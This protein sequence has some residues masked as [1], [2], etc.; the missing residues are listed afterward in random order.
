MNWEHAEAIGVG[1]EERLIGNCRH[2]RK[3]EEGFRVP[4]GFGDF[5]FLW[6][7]K[8]RRTRAFID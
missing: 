7:R 1:G 3:L 8:E 4:G 6:W 5:L 2:G